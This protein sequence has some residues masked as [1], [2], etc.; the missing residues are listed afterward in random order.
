MV[1]YVVMN[2]RGQVSSEPFNT[3]K[4][5]EVFAEQLNLESAYD[6]AFFFVVETDDVSL[7]EYALRGCT[8]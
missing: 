8:T 1:A 4:D 5:A 2:N 6:G 3:R 7:M